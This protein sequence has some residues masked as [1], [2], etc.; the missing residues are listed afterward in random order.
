MHEV[1]SEF[2]PGRG[3]RGGKWTEIIPGV[4]VVDHAGGF[5]KMA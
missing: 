3:D 1:V 2:G 5:L 4:A